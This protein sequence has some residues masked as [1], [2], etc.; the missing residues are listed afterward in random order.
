M[1]P[2]SPA[3]L[4]ADGA[5]PSRLA[6]QP[7]TGPAVGPPGGPATSTGSPVAAMNPVTTLLNSSGEVTGQLWP[8]CGATH[9]RPPGIPLASS[10]AAGTARQSRE[11]QMTSA[12][13]V[14][15]GR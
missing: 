12:G 9:T 4:S 1:V 7:S 3:G 11:P 8:W 10:Q 5:A 13:A 15:S 2:G 6:D 14:I